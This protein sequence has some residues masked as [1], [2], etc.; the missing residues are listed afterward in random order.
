MKE[1]QLI[2]SPL[3]TKV[4]DDDYVLFEAMSWRLLREGYAGYC[5]MSGNLTSGRINIRLLLHRL[6]MSARTGQQ[7]DHINGDKLDNRK[8]N[9]RFC[10]SS[11]NV[12][13]SV[14]HTI[15]VSRFKGVCLK[16]DYDRKKPWFAYIGSASNREYL[17]HYKTEIEAAL[18]YN[19][20]AVRIA[21]EFARLNQI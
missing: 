19:R 20:A 6:V 3:T 21:G 12:F 9:L 14:K 16:G 5:T 1:I 17:G 8:S 4:D 18:A 11:Q 10:N 13:N 7:I 15:G 2:N